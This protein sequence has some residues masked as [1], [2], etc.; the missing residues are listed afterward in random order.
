MK[1][2]L[3]LTYRDGEGPD[4]GSPEFDAEMKVWHALNEELLAAGQLVTASG[5][6][7]GLVVSGRQDV[8]GAG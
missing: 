6:K 1:Y 4:E 7:P 8:A 5:L 3:M 2:L